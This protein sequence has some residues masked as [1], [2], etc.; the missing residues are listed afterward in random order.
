MELFIFLA[1]GYAIGH[2]INHPEKVKVASE[3]VKNTY[4]ILTKKED[5]TTEQ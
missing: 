5:S 1:I 4:K 2:G 3:R